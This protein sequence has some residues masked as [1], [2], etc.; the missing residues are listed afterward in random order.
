MIASHDALLRNTLQVLPIPMR[1]IANATGSGTALDAAT[2]NGP[3][4]DSWMCA[5]SGRAEQFNL[6]EYFKDCE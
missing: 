1:N 3:L 6:V 2:L 5:I 4:I